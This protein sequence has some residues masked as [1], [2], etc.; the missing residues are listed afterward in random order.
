LDL[1][2]VYSQQQDARR[3]HK[4]QGARGKKGSQAA[5]G[6]KQEV[7]KQGEDEEAEKKKK[8]KLEGCHCGG[9]ASQVCK[10][11]SGANF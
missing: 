8:K 4:Q 3:N 9:K 11:E 6:K 7:R 10:L 5:R 1:E 2:L